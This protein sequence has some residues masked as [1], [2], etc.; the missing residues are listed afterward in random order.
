MHGPF[1]GP[2]AARRAARR[3]SDLTD[4]RL[5]NY[6]PERAAV[7]PGR[8]AIALVTA[9]D[10]GYEA[11]DKD[12]RFTIQSVSKAIVYGLALEDWGHAEVRH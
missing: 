6:I 2:A 3:Y 12:A 11:G 4:G 1:P 8:F 10:S 5:A 7:D 9:D